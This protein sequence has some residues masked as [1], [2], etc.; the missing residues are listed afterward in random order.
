METNIVLD[1]QMLRHEVEALETK[2]SYKELYALSLIIEDMEDLLQKDGY[3]I[4]R[5]KK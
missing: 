2:V 3:N 4:I 5:Q 1:M